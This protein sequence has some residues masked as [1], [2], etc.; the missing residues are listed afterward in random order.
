MGTG[1]LYKVM[2]VSWNQ[3]VVKVAQHSKC[4]KIH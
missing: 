3:V 4:T 1:F 2:E